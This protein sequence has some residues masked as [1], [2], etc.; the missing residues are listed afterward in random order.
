MFSPYQIPFFI[1]YF[2]GIDAAVS[3][4]LSR[5]NPP[6]ETT[7][8]EE[9]CALM[10]ADSQR[11]ENLLKFD[12]DALQTALSLPRDMLGVDFTIATHQHGQKLEAFVSQADFGLIL[13][14]RN[15]VLPNLNWKTAYLMQAKRLFPDTGGGYSVASKFSSTSVDQQ[16]RMRDIAKILGERA[17]Q[18]WLYMPQTTDYDVNSTSAIRNLHSR[19]LM[20][21]IYDYAV[22]LALHEALQ[23][24]GGVDAGMWIAN[25]ES[26]CKNAADVHKGA[27]NSTIPFTWFILEHFGR[28]SSRHMDDIGTAHDVSTERV[29]KIA[30]GDPTTS[31]ELIDELGDRARDSDFDPTRMKVLPGNSITIRVTS[32]PPEGIDLPLSR[33]SRD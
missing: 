26:T 29:L 23:Q 13:D 22:G 32:G 14:Y 11:R 18:Y 25:L 33:T 20:D 10:D 19:N 30:T 9:F 5:R 21:N 28:L 27:F 24:S 16:S 3:K 2:D 17:I 8:T 4:R 15:T 7:L 1:R 31:Q 12:A 6:T